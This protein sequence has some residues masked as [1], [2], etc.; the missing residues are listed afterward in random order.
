MD[1]ITHGEFREWQ[2]NRVSKNTN[3]SKK[4]QLRTIDESGEKNPGGVVLE[5]K[6]GK[7]FQKWVVNNVDYYWEIK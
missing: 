2:E 3:I 6:R 5:Y 7:F 4:R 1:K